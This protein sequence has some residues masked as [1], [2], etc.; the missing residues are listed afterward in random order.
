MERATNLL[1]VTSN[2]ASS[3]HDQT[4]LRLSPRRLW[5][6]IALRSSSAPLVA[7]LLALGIGSSPSP[8]CNV[9]RYGDSAALTDA[10]L[11]WD[12]RAER[13][14]GRRITGAIA[15]SWRRLSTRSLTVRAA[16]AA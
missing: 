14:R 5:A 9:S 15:K 1:E 16:T 3:S 10:E 13:R 4:G 6:H 11:V 12:A 7:A 2:R 8:L